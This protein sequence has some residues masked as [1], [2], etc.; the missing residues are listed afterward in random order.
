MPAFRVDKFSAVRTKCRSPM[1]KR[2]MWNSPALVLIVNLQGVLNPYLGL[3]L[4]DP[5]SSYHWNSRIWPPRIICP[6]GSDT[7]VSSWA[8][9]TEEKVSGGLRLLTMTI[10]KHNIKCSSTIFHVYC[11]SFQN[12]HSFFRA[13]VLF[14]WFRTSRGIFV[15]TLDY[16]K[17]LL[18][19]RI[20]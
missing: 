14:S 18:C 19:K 2:T 4:I 20:Y 5:R 8:L 17:I 11:T 10:I 3:D 1:L 6:A 12:Y 13:L 9:N 16:I 15:W 7:P